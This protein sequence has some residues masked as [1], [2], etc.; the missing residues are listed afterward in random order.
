MGAAMALFM[1]VTIGLLWS[2]N[3]VSTK[4]ARVDSLESTNSGSCSK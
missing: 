1:P 4:L 3:M 2:L